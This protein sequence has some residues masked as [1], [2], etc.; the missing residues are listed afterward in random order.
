MNLR[1]L[2]YI[3]LGLLALV[4][5]LSSRSV[6]PAHERGVMLRFGDVT[7]IGLEPGVYWRL[8]VAETLRRIDMRTRFSDLDQ[9]EYVDARGDAMRVD[10][11]V[12]WRI[13][14]LPRFYLRTGADNARAAE[15]LQPVLREGLRRAFAAALWPEQRAGLPAE[16]L[17]GIVRQS[18]QKL[19][20][21]LG[22]ELL[23]L[24]IKRISFTPPVQAV[25]IERMRLARDSQA[26]TLR[27]EALEQAA[28]VRGAGEQ[29]QRG[30]LAQAE[31]D[32]TRLRAEAAREAAARVA[33]VARQDPA[34]ARY[35][36]ALADWQRGFGKPGDVFVLAEGS[37]LA[38]LRNKL[39]L[40]NPAP[41]APA[42]PNETQAK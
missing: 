14:D 18:N 12:T 24:R 17:Q 8:P 41:P 10:A 33:E 20:R 26:A 6:V 27:A 31:Q 32:V 22:V 3:T 23:S 13:R 4:L 37:E 15:L 34:L 30:I 5:V 21:E 1:L 9:E 7:R 28:A 40:E 35:W 16:T 42:K 36:Q 11:W 19:E 29:E 39:H 25:V 38:A 2:N